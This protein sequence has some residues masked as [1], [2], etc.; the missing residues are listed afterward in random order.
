MFIFVEHILALPQVL[1]QQ[2][3]GELLAKKTKKMKA[4]RLT[5]SDTPMFKAFLQ[6]YY[7]KSWE[8]LEKEMIELMAKSFQPTGEDVKPE[9]MAKV[10]EIGKAKFEAEKAKA[11][12]KKVKSE[13]EAKLRATVL[14]LAKK[15]NMPASQIA[16]VLDMEEELVK[17]IIEEESK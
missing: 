10:L 8:E 13:A 12:A 14:N 7:G 4:L 6:L 17:K 5:E 9:V 3:V 2:I 16:D 1:N 11:E 15:M